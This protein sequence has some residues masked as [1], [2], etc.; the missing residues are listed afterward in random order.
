M[1]EKRISGQFL[2]RR[3]TLPYRQCVQTTP[4]R[5]S[6]TAELTGGECRGPVHTQHKGTRKASWSRS[7]SALAYGIELGKQRP[8]GATRKAKSFDTEEE[9][10]NT[11]PS[12]GKEDLHEL[13]R[14]LTRLFTWRQNTKEQEGDEKAKVWT[15]FPL[16][17]S[18]TVPRCDREAWTWV[19]PP[20]KCG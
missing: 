6:L 2:R 14:K 15:V 13:N 19:S 1:V 16:C 12:F 9:Q 20:I 4:Q 3:Q 10:R 8:P 5:Q 7:K 11:H 17:Y 18:L